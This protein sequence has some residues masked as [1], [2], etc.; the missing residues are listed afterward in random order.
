MI[1]AADDRRRPSFTHPTVPVCSAGRSGKARVWQASPSVARIFRFRIQTCARWR[2]CSGP[3][4]VARGGMQVAWRGRSH[5][6]PPAHP[7]GP[8]GAR[9]PALQVWRGGRGRWLGGA[10]ATWSHLPRP[11]WRTCSSPPRVAREGG[12]VAWRGLKPPVLG[13]L[14]W[15]LPSPP[16]CRDALPASVPL[17]R[18]VSLNPDRHRDFLFSRGKKSDPR[19]SQ[20]K[21]YVFARHCVVAVCRPLIPPL[22]RYFRS[23]FLCTKKS[24]EKKNVTK[25]HPQSR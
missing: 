11:R 17:C 21:N 3:P 14:S 5:L 25:K 22:S 1:V 10:E 7:S 23:F 20:K 12:Q 13:T 19:L 16:P 2:T 15:V 9:A 24:S 18:C 4:G 8:G 6:A